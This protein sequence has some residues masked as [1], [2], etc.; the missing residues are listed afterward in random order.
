M[1]KICFGIESKLGIEQEIGHHRRVDIRQLLHLFFA[2][3]MASSEGLG[4]Y[5]DAVLPAAWD[6]SQD[7]AILVGEHAAIL[8]E[9]LRNRGQQKFIHLLA[10]QL[11]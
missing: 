4:L 1:T 5:V 11:G 2:E 8:H 7:I 9:E 6:F 10:W 3:L